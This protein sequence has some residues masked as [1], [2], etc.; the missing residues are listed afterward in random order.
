M[1]Y[2]SII[3]LL[4]LSACAMPED[5][6]QIGTTMDWSNCTDIQYGGTGNPKTV[7]GKKGPICA[8][9]PHEGQTNMDYQP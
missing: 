9:N 3:L 1:K 5:P 7:D 2:L 8:Y 6:I 4:A